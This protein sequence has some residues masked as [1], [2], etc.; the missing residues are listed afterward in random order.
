MVFSANTQKQELE[1]VTSTDGT[2][3]INL[4]SDRTWRYESRNLYNKKQSLGGR[5]G[6]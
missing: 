3:T 2:A 5:K 6:I 4:Q 1:R